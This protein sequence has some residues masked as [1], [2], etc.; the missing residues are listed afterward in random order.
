M[1]TINKVFGD[2]LKT[3]RE[4]AGLRQEDVG[5]W[6][7]MQKSTVSQW[8][9]GRLPHASIIAELATKFNTSTD[10]LLGRTDVQKYTT[11]D[12]LPKDFFPPMVAEEIERYADYLK[13]FKEKKYTPEEIAEVADFIRK[14]SK[15]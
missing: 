2:R 14:H 1:E 11:Y 10:Y 15:K 6:F 13:V 5:E 8:E 7:K 4:Q 3:L 12:V 9:S